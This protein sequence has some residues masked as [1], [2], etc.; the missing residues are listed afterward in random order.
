MAITHKTTARPHLR[1]DGNFGLDKFNR[2]TELEKKVEELKN[3]I[4][5]VWLLSD[6]KQ[7]KSVYEMSY[8]EYMELPY[9]SRL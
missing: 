1:L 7:S 5:E 3:E 4:A 6:V 2:I 9:R 8:E